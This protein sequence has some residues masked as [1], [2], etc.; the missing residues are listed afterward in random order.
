M[1]TLLVHASPERTTLLLFKFSTLYHRG[2]LHKN[3][4][5]N[6]KIVPVVARFAFFLCLFV[7]F[8]VLHM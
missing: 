1:A 3:T 4:H 2:R 6:T 8:F 7:L 5:L